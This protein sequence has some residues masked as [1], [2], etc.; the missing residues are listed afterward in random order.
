MLNSIPSKCISGQVP[1]TVRGYADPVEFDE[2]FPALLSDALIEIVDIRDGSERPKITSATCSAH[3]GLCAICPCC[4]SASDDRPP[5]VM[6]I[7][8]MLTIWRNAGGISGGAVGM[9]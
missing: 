3:A 2:M 9:A 1:C 5:V 7:A 8:N 4:I 6:P